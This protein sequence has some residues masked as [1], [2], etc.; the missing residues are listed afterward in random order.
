MSECLTAGKT[1]PMMLALQQEL[2]SVDELVHESPKA[3]QQKIVENF[4]AGQ[5]PFKLMQAIA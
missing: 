2:P 1:I 3:R 5:F 4:K